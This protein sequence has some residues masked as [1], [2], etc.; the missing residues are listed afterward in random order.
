VFIPEQIKASR[1]HQTVNNFAIVSSTLNADQ[2]ASTTSQLQ[3]IARKNS[4]SGAPVI[5]AAAVSTTSEGSVG[6]VPAPK[7]SPATS[8]DPTKLPSHDHADAVI[9]IGVSN[10]PEAVDEAT[11]AVLY[12]EVCGYI[13]AFA[14]EAE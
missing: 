8:A 12:T 4:S 6:K 5:F 10:D 11:P 2:T 3:R 1:H 14:E 13:H 9:S 7:A